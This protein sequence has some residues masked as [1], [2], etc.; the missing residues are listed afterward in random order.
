MNLVSLRR[1]DRVAWM[2]ERGADVHHANSIGVTL[3]ELIAAD[4]I[5]E[6]SPQYQWR[7]KVINVLAVKGV[8]VSVQPARK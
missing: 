1:Y 3:A 8:K 5:A 2:I 4:W 7:L 6:S